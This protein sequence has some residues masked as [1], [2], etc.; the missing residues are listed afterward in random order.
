MQ[1]ITEEERQI[2]RFV[3]QNTTNAQIAEELGY[4]E[5]SIERKVSAI[6]KKFKAENRVTLV[7]K[8]YML[9]LCGII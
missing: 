5:R 9:F 6:Y 8:S 1:R 4:C 3:I 2:I 7:T